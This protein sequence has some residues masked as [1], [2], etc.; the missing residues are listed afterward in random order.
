M[1]GGFSEENS[2]TGM[3]NFFLLGLECVDIAVFV[4]VLV[5]V[6]TVQ[7]WDLRLGQAQARA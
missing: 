3:N 2:V 5:Q 7:A 6:L 1:V 4:P